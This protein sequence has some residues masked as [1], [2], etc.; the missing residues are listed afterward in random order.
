MPI[1]GACLDG[2][3]NLQTTRHSLVVLPLGIPGQ[4]SFHIRFDF[5]GASHCLVVV[6]TATTSGR[7]ITASLHIRFDFQGA[8][9]CLVVVVRHAIAS[10]NATLN[11]QGAS[12]CLIVVGAFY[13]TCFHIRF[14][15]HS[16][17]SFL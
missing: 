17:I 1:G 5:Q 3:L 9:Q 4:T 6:Q 8:N 14:D 16:C 13:P 2:G 10:L 7:T 15:F 12:R 11:L